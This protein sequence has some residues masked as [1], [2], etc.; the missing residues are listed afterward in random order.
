[1]HGTHPSGCTS[2]CQPVGVGINE[3]LKFLFDLDI[4]VYVIAPSIRQ[5]IVEWVKKE[6]YDIGTDIV[7]NVYWHGLYKWF[8]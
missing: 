3:L 1:M 2:L 7:S 4:I 8:D 6:C 5:Q